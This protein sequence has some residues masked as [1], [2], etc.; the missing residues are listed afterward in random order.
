LGPFKNDNRLGRYAGMAGYLLADLGAATNAE[1]HP[2]PV[3]S[4]VLPLALRL[5]SAQIHMITP[6]RSF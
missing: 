1:S 2:A 6:V 4:G 3:S 5:Q